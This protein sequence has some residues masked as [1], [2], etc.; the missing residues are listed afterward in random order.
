MKDRNKK[1]I[2]RIAIIGLGLIGGS[3][4]KILSKKG[5]E[6][7]G[8]SKSKSTVNKA[9]KQKIINVGSLALS[10]NILSTTDLI[11]ICTP[12]SLVESKIRELSKLLKHNV[13]VTDVGSTKIGIC[14]SAKKHFSSNV[15]FIG[16]HPMA[17]NEFSGIDYADEKLF[18]KTAWVLTP[19]NNKSKTKIKDLENVIKMTGG[20]PVISSPQ[21]HDKAVALIS[22]L[23]I[24]ISSSLCSLIMKSK[25]RVLAEKLASS[26]FRDTTRVAGGNPIL[27]KD[28]T[29]LNAKEIAKL[30]SEYSAEIKKTKSFNDFSKISK[31]RKGLYSSNG[32]NTNLL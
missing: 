18:E 16:G 15:T 21:E 9:L 26:G 14:N 13:I 12:L 28:L 10:E 7:I 8:I 30:L 11:F 20:K 6:V 1:K 2:K 3:L 22:H 23:P 25:N 29:T 5:F 4:A 17:G 27:N 24:L 31:W 32:K 19:I